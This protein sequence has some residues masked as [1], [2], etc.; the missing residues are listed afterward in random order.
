MG[1]Q[2][3]KTAQITQHTGTNQEAVSGIGGGRGLVK[4]E[5]GHCVALAMGI[6]GVVTWET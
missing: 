6:T 4:V 3:A 2:D 1:L 5:S